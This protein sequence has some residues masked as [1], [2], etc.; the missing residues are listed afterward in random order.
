MVTW[1]S[2]LFSSPAH[3]SHLETEAVGA[4]NPGVRVALAA[5]DRVGGLGWDIQEGS[6]GRKKVTD[7]WH[8]FY[9]DWLCKISY[10]WTKGGLKI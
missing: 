9:P 4:S 8:C 7:L 1:R 2:G 5:S 10:G 3:P 6:V